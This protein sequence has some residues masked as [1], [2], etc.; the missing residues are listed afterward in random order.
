MN[1]NQCFLGE[2]TFGDGQV[3]H[4]SMKNVIIHNKTTLKTSQKNYIKSIGR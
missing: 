3:L 1:N 2:E 4:W